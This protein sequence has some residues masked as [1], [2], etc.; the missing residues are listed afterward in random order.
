MPDLATLEGQNRINQFI[1]DDIYLIILDNLSCLLRTGKEND[2]ESWQI[3]QSW[4][5]NLRAQGK[6]VLLIH[7]QG[8]S[9]TQR[10]S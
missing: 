10:G 2:A 7:H 6:S 1:T 3:I 8:K 9:G 4:I 5:L